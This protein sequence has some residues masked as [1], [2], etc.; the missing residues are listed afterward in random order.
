MLLCLKRATIIP[1]L[2]RPG[3]DQEEMTNYRPISNLH[4]ISKLI[5]NVVARCI[6]E[7]LEQNDLNDIY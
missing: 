5:E 7:Y 1:L 2:K 4:F 3:L 6:E